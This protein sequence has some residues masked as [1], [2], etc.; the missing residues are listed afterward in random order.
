MLPDE[1]LPE[2]Q[3]GRCSAVALGNT[4]AS[5]TVP[6]RWCCQ[7]DLDD[8]RKRRFAWV[9]D[10]YPRQSLESKES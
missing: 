6:V 4:G 9:T 10:A 7:S 3:A 8:R 1:A 5:R 2:D